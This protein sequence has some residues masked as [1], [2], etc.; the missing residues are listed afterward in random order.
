[1]I[2]NKLLVINS[3]L[4]AAEIYMNLCKS[5]YD[6]LYFPAELELQILF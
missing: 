3:V 5:K 2:W 1:M 6:K 4:P